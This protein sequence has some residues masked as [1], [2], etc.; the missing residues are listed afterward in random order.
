MK[1][2]FLLAI[3]SVGALAGARAVGDIVTLTDGTTVA[4][5]LHKTDDGWTVTDASGNIT[6]ISADRVAS[7]QVTSNQPPNAVAD[8]RLH[9][10][11]NSVANLNDL[12]EIIRRYQAFI[13][14][15]QDT[16]AAA[17]AM[18]DLQIWQDRQTKGQVK[19]GK[20]W[21]MPADRAAIIAKSLA[22]AIEAR[23]LMSQ[24]RAR[25]AD[26]VLVQALGDDPDNTAA[27][28]LRGLIFYDQGKMPEAR[29]MFQAVLDNDPENGPTLNNM[30]VVMFRQKQYGG[31]MTL[32]DRAML[33]M[34]LCKD[35][36]NNVAEAFHA[37][38]DSEKDT[39]PSTRA[40]RE[41]AGQDVK[42]QAI[43]A[44]QGWYRWGATWVNQKQYDALQAADAQ[45][46][47]QLADLQKRFDALSDQ[48]SSID[49][50]IASNNRSLRQ[51]E[52]NA[53]GRDSNGN[54]V[55]L[56]Y[57]QTYYDIEQDNTNLTQQRQ[58]VVAQEDAL[59]QQAQ[60]VQQS[61][62]VPKFTGIQ[63]TMG[64]EY[65]PMQMP[66]G[67]PTTAP[68]QVDPSQGAAPPDA[69]PPDNA[70]NSPPAGAAPPT[71]NPPAPANQVP[72]TPAAGP[73]PP[74]Q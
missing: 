33:A 18:S 47:Q 11:R 13:A 72:Q 39:T 21:I 10:L 61:G 62:P 37:L 41:F 28:Y 57:P 65:A 49:Q 32:Y 2:A 31:S 36:L 35:I 26:S 73:T 42:L 70:S 48:V 54:T 50:S 53:W 15:Y 30:A 17:A 7:I 59:R 5:M 64:A 69:N 74:P 25:E 45:I 34:P 14:K 9:S 51:I 22:G 44:Q 60:Q 1:R 29:Q 38:P 16:P 24:G 43:M 52:A 4:G 40:A 23:T 19:L 66:N 71:V 67:L 12:G 3:V 63:Q 20:N 55:Q 6:T 27:L 8:D 56:A 68:A 46:K 58:Q